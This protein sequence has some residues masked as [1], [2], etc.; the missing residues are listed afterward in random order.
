MYK[1]R[2]P[3]C[4]GWQFWHFDADKK[5]V[6]IDML[7]Q[8]IRGELADAGLLYNGQIGLGR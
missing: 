5:P 4:N 8:Q 2:P 7:R 6:P 1:A 3:S